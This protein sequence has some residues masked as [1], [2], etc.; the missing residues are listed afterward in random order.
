MSEITV[1]AESFQVVM[2]LKLLSRDMSA[3]RAA[4]RACLTEI[5]IG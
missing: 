3:F 1:F 2:N 5:W 4:T